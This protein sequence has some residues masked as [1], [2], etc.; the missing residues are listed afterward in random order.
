MANGIGRIFLRKSVEQIQAEHEQGELKRSLGALNLVL[1]GI[2]CIIGTGIF[3]LT[4]RAAAQFAGPGIMVSFVITGLLCAFVALCYA[5]LASALPVSGSAYSYTYASM[6]E[7]AAWVMGLLLVLEYGLAASTVAVGWSGYFVSLMHDIGVNIPAALQAAPGV[8]VKDHAGNVI[9]TGMFNLP[10][11]V[12]IALV[13]LL[14]VR[15]VTESATVNNIVVAIKVTVVILFIVI[16]F[17]YVDVAQWSPLI[18]AE[19]PARPPGT[20]NGLLAQI[21]R[22]L[23]DVIT[24]NSDYKYGIGGIIHAAAV[25]FFAYLGFEAVSTAGA[26]SR[27]P[28]KDMPIGIL[29]ALTICTVLYILTCAVLVGVVPYSQLDVPAP[30]ALAADKMGLPWF[31]YVVK[32]G[33]IAGLSSVMLVLLYGQTRV[34][35]TMSRDGLLP[36]ALSAVHKTFKTPWINTIVVGIAAMIAAGF[37]SLDALSDLTNVGS[38]A[39]FALVCI[40]VIYLRIT[41]K[42]MVRPFRT[43]LYPVVPILGAAMCVILLLSL[44]AGEHTRNFFLIY[45]VIGIAVYFLYGIRASKLGRGIRVAGG[46]GEPHELPHRVGEPP[47]GQG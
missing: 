28:G 29:G 8:E 45:L 21:G 5:E 35:Y 41:H 11:L 30:I 13:T 46:E 26:E 2:G 27:N 10:A 14:L 25:I 47:E 9:G 32:V 16:G 42:E 33:A 39:A 22:A 20:D 1:L 44:M 15:G 43:P 4:G 38:L 18:P 37:L 19:I 24:G 31:S 3:V 12:A 36:P 7:G 40:T 6:G 34:F 17:R 23:G